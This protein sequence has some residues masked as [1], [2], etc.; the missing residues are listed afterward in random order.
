MKKI[1]IQVTLEVFEGLKTLPPEIQSIVIAA[2]EARENA[3]AP[4]SN[5]KVGAAI[6]LDS[7]DIVTGNNQENAAY[8]SGLCAERVA[9]FQ[10]A[11]KFPERMF[12]AIA[13]VAQS[14]DKTHQDPVPPCGA[15]RQVLAEYEDKQDAPLSIYFTGNGQTIYKASSTKDILPFVF[16]KAFLK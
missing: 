5:F 12:K 14:Q 1:A 10:A 6:L 9:V 3:Y 15:C 7:H 8:P 2:Q 4:Y 13:I 16:S 11:S